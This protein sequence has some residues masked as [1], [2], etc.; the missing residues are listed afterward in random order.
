M[1]FG[2]VFSAP[3]Q[4][5]GVP[6]PE[7]IRRRTLVALRWVALAG[8]VIAVAAAW[9]VGARFVLAPLLLCIGVPALL[10]L[11]LARAK[12]GPLSERAAQGQLAFDILQLGALLMLTGGTAN[13]FA[14]LI[15]APVAVAATA[16]H[17]RSTLALVALTV[18]VVIAFAL[19]HVPLRFID[20]PPLDPVDAIE[21]AHGIALVLACAFLGAYIGRVASEMSDTSDALFATQLALA[22]EQRLQHLGGIV[23]AAA[24]E[25]GTP[26][27]TI[28][29]ISSEL[30]DELAD[31]LRDRPA[32]AE[33]LATLRLSA[34]RCRD[35]MRDMGSAGRDDLLLYAAPLAE[36]VSVAAAPHCER[37]R[38]VVIELGDLG[39]LTVRRDAGIIHALRNLIQNAVDFSRKTVVLTASRAGG[40]LRLTVQD[41]GPGY[42]PALLPRLGD[43][44][45]TTRRGSDRRSDDY[46]GMGLGLFIARALLERSGARLEL[47]N[48]GG[49]TATVIWPEHR[50][51]ADNRIALGRNPAIEH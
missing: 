22:R 2:P 48:N 31:E 42:P 7:P 43:P 47:T 29:L 50:I 8:Q 36:I 32:L 9:L 30:A 25:M 49:A 3:P 24:H 15:T 16:L 17:R 21:L 41:D 35:I 14:M 6:A 27:A 19:V 11:W 51:L 4:P 5:G 45:L 26:L 37:G 38:Q 34:D 40:E 44:F 12:A 33:D 23:A 18:A 20:A 10:N 1:P 13:P 39:A 46:E 28:K